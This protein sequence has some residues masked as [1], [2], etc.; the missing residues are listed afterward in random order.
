[1]ADVAAT[2]NT[3][4]R[5]DDGTHYIVSRSYICT[6][7]ASAGQ[8]ELWPAVAAASSHRCFANLPSL[9]TSQVGYPSFEQT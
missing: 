5:S 1:M 4:L 2:F 3:A 8:R 6:V 9:L 7:C